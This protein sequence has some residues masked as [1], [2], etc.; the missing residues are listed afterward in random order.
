MQS[1]RSARDTAA[2]VRG[3]LLAEKQRLSMVFLTFHALGLRLGLCLDI[4]M[5]ISPSWSYNP[6]NYIYISLCGQFPL[7]VTFFNVPTACFLWQT[8][9]WP[10]DSL[11]KP[12]SC[13]VCPKI[14]VP[15]K[16]IKS[17][18]VFIISFFPLF[19]HAQNFLSYCIL[20]QHQHGPR[21][22]WAE[23]HGRPSDTCALL[24]MTALSDAVADRTDRMPMDGD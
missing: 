4:V 10:P 23:A 5:V 22:H 14:R 8:R 9:T 19:R 13:R 18:R 15:L 6:Y 21:C 1:P 17:P 3:H 12:S 20:W 11:R 24:S 2:E 7:P 16:S